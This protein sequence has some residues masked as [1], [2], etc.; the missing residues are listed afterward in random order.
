M[1]YLPGQQ[2]VTVPFF[3]PE[4]NIHFDYFPLLETTPKL[5]SELLIVCLEFPCEKHL[6]NQRRCYDPYP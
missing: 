1:V 5:V 6:F 2:P 4:F 3:N